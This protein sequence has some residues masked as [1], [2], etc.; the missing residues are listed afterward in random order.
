MFHLFDEPDKG[1]LFRLNISASR[2]VEIH[3]EQNGNRE[4]SE[5]EKRKKGMTN[6]ADAEIVPH[7]A[8]GQERE[9]D[10]KLDDV[11]RDPHFENPSPGGPQIEYLVEGSQKKTAD[12]RRCGPRY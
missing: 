5:E 8:H 6:P 4:G 3:D 9:G 11:G 10:K 1:R 7:H 12:G 2:S